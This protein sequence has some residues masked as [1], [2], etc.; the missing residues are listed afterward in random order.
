M[1][2][3]FHCEVYEIC[4]LLGCY[5]AYTGNVYMSCKPAF[6][7]IVGLYAVACRDVLKSCSVLCNV[8]VILL[9]LA[10]K[11]RHGSVTDVQVDTF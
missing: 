10:C 4:A 5:A 2:L 9:T 7:Y 3:G 11:E 8:T 1:I 6:C